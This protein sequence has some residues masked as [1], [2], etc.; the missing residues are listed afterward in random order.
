MF[1]N[2]N[3]VPTFYPLSRDFLAR[4]KRSMEILRVDYILRIL[5]TTLQNPFV[6]QI[7]EKECGK[8]VTSKL[9]YTTLAK[10]NKVERILM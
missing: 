6:K 4:V 3:S 8:S 5:A 9:E 10:V 2:N 1:N 7:V